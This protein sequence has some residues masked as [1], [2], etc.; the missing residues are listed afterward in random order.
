MKCA[1]GS[2]L[3][4]HQARTQAPGCGERT[5]TRLGEDDAGAIGWLRPAVAV[6][7]FPGQDAR[8]FHRVEDHRREP[9]VQVVGVRLR[10]R[11]TLRQL[12]Q[13]GRWAAEV[14]HS[15]QH[16]PTLY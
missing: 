10:T 14:A 9:V 15:V 8:L 6:E 16:S 7:A 1:Y 4:R 2:G 11:H 12:A 5:A 13:Q 3:V